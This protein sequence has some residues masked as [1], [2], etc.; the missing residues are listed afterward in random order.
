M[1]GIFCCCSCSSRCSCTMSW[2]RVD[3][4]SERDLGVVSLMVCSFL[5][6]ENCGL[7]TENLACASPVHEGGVNKASIFLKSSHCVV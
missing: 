5:S 3:R 1:S 2:W 7:L 4:E 6:V